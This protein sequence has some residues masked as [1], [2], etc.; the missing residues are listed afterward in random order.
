MAR[1]ERKG[2]EEGKRKEEKV[3][4]DRGKKKKLERK[5]IKRINNKWESRAEDD[6]IRLA[7]LAELSRHLSH[8]K[9]GTSAPE[10]TFLLT[11]SLFSSDKLRYLDII[12]EGHTRVQRVEER[13][14]KPS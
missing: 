10:L 3:E 4:M 8:V 14:P 2:K 5:K 7:A 13:R 1:G 11:S 12:A 6:L 9:F